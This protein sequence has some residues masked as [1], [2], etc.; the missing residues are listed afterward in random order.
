MHLLC[1]IST[2]FERSIFEGG[3]LIY[4]GAA[5]IKWLEFFF[6]L[7]SLNFFFLH[8][9]TVSIFFF[10][11]ALLNGIDSV[12]KVLQ[13]FREQGKHL[14]VVAGYHGILI[15]VF[16]CEKTF[17]TCVEVTAGT[18]WGFRSVFV[19]LLSSAWGCEL[20]CCESVSHCIDADTSKRMLSLGHER[21]LQCCIDQCMY[22]C[23][24]Y[25]THKNQVSQSC[26]FLLVCSC[27]H[28]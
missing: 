7:L 4:S 20:F 23:M 14:D 13:S 28:Y 2:I 24:H 6:H 3:V 21:E 12:K 9:L 5:F 22:I 27:F 18:R 11:Q 19:K 17:F 16:D 25:Y 1:L 26:S 15:E 8:C 10:C